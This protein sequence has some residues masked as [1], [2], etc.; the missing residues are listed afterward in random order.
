MKVVQ[1]KDTMSNIYLDAVRIRHQVFV[2]EQGVPLSR[3]IDKDEAHCI[4]FVLY[5]DKKEPQG[6]VRLLP[7]E[8]GK[9]KLQRMAILSEY[10]HQGLGKI[11]IEEAENW[12]FVNKD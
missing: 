5:S 4:H 8:N 12:L 6:T 3:E 11:L 9:M 7:L 1:T 10:R 2:V